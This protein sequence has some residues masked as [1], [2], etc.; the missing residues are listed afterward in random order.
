MNTNIISIY[1]DDPVS[2][3]E[4][5]IK[6][7]NYINNHYEFSD[8]VIISDLNYL[9][10]DIDASVL[11]SFY[12]KFFSG[13]VIFLD[14]QDYM[15]Y[16]DNMMCNSILYLETKDIANIDRNTIKNCDILTCNNNNLTLI[17]NY[18]LQ[19]TI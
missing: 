4:T 15:L 11:S 9:D 18:E 13:S 2:N 10:K 19:Q 1:T 14:P 6:I 5:I 7:K 8:F 17:K 12:L 3:K 16:S